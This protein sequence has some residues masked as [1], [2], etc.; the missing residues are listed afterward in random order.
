MLPREIEAK[1]FAD[2]GPVTAR[3]VNREEKQEEFEL[4]ARQRLWEKLSVGEVPKVNTGITFYEGAY[5]DYPEIET[6]LEYIGKGS[7]SPYFPSPRRSRN[8][9]TSRR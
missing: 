7:S 8:L 5:E 6:N 9:R 4:L 2:A 3:G 1:I